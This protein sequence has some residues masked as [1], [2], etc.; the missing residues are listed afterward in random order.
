MSS[1]LRGRADK[2]FRMARR[3]HFDQKDVR[4][5]RIRNQQIQADILVDSAI[6]RIARWC[7][8]DR[9]TLT[10][11]S[12]SR[13]TMRQ[14]LTLASFAWLSRVA[15]LPPPTAL[16]TYERPKR[17]YIFRKHA[18]RDVGAFQRGLLHP[19]CLSDG[20]AGRQAGGGR[21]VSQ[22]QATAKDTRST[23]PRH[24]GQSI[25]DRR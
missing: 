23:G 4:R 20:S 16:E 2:D 18:G 17:R 19:P 15:I 6:E 11:R 9:Q 5:N 3:I 12:T 25:A 8:T 21:W 7:V 10:F 22:N 1:G 14:R 13:A 24:L